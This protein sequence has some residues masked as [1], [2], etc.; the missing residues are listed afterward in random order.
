MGHQR[1]A[2]LPRAK[3]IA[4]N[5]ELPRLID[6]RFDA[7]NLAELVV[8]LQPVVFHPVLDP[9]TWK[10]VLLAVGQ[11]FAVE[12]RV[13]TA[14]Q[15]GE[16][17]L[18]GEAQQGMLEQSRIEFGQLGSTLEQDIG[19]VLGLVDDPVVVGLAEPGPGRAAG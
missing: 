7:Q 9:S 4:T 10:T 15:E 18:G 13:Q 3:T 6:D 17:V 8:H 11:D 5:L 12:A 1:S 19:A 14:A 2:A 16:D